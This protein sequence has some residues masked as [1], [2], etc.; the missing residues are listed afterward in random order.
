MLKLTATA[1]IGPWG[2]SIEG[3]ADYADMLKAEEEQ[4]RSIAIEPVPGFIESAFNPMVYQI[5]KNH[6]ES[7]TIRSHQ[8]LAI[9]LGSAF[10]DTAT[11]DRASQNLLQGKVHNPLLFY[12]SVPNSILGYASK[13]FG[14]T[15]MISAVSH[16]GNG[17]VS[18]LDLAE[19]YMDQP[20]VEQVLVIGVELQSSRSDE[21][22]AELVD[23]EAA[24][25]SCDHAISLL[26]ECAKGDDFSD[27]G[28]ELLIY[29]EAV[30]SLTEPLSTEPPVRPFA[31][32][33][34]LAD[35][36]IA[37]DRLKNREV[38]APVIIYDYEFG[39]GCHAIKLNR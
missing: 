22:L 5:L 8:K 29:I 12:Q 37:V 34:G 13:Q 28:E 3:L 30:E 16:F 36:V 18:L 38:A 17:L 35:L 1:C 31:G 14:F 15:G 26:L 25:R 9:L 10:G 4:A 32:N 20:D 21:L 6:V 24:M 7:G 33:Q 19:I 11:A 27:S 2:H 39:G 23:S